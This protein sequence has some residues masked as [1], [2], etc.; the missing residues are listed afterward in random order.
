MTVFKTYIK[1]LLSSK[2]TVILYTVMLI[3]FGILNMETKEV[4]TDFTST[5]P[6]ILIINND[7]NE[8]ITKSLIEYISNNSNI[9]EIENEEDK[10]ADALLYRDVNYIIYIPKNFRKDFLKG[11]NP[12]IEIKTT[13][14]Y[15]SQVANNLLSKYIEVAKTYRSHINNEEEYIEKIEETLKTNTEVEIASS[16]DNNSLTKAKTFF[17]FSNYTMLA[18]SI[19]IICLIMTV[20]NNETIRK[21]T[22]ISSTNYKKLNR[23]LILSNSIFAFTLCIIYIIISFILVGDTMISS[24]GLLYIINLFVFTITVITISFLIGKLT[25]N[26]EAISGIVNVIALGSSFLCGS[27]VPIEYLP[28]FVTK[29]AHI[30]PSYWYIKTNEEISILENITIETIKPIITNMIILFIFTIIFIIIT[31]IITKRQRTIA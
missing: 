25:N 31:N 24:H 19:F 29:I 13:E 1:V 7:E 15:P 8:G 20:F 5:K 4:G 21:R 28:N 18:G 11:T 26:K 30:L 9:K 12:N 3:I 16:L 22:I 17:N 27:F 2:F 14:D 10:I 23:K 6:D